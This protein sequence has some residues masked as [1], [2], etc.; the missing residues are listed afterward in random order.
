MQKNVA[1]PAGVRCT[2]QAISRPVFGSTSTPLIPS[3]AEIRSGFCTSG[4][5]ERFETAISTTIA[6]MVP[7]SAT[8]TTFVGSANPIIAP[9]IELAEA[10]NPDIQVVVRTH[11]EDELAHL[12]A[13]YS[14]KVVMGEQELARAMLLYV[15]RQF[16]V[17]PERAR[18][19]VDEPAAAD[20]DAEAERR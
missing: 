10:T 17:P 18:R 9:R 2:C 4:N 16:G 11:S 15:L 19:L 3:A 7:P 6:S 5:S 13:N 20:L 8:C 14:G 1:S 12:R